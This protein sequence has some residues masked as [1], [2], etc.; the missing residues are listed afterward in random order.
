MK[1]IWILTAMSEEAQYIID[2]YGLQKTQS[3]ATISF[4]E[5]DKIVL[6]LAGVGKVQ[7][8]IATTLLLQ[9]FHPQY[10]INIGIAGSLVGREA[11]VGDV[12]LID[13]IIQHD[14]YLPFEGEHLDYAK[15]EIT[16]PFH[17]LCDSHNFDFTFY[18]SWKCL[19]WDQFLDDE[20]KVQSLRKQRNAQV[21]EMEAFAFASV[22]REFWKLDSSIVIKAVSDGGDSDAKSAHMDNLDFAMQN[23]LSVLHKVITSLS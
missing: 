22:A 16:L 4:Y 15:G 23:S 8:S 2:H 3:L 21:V 17:P 11:K 1:K 7:A 12:F 19:T 5:N 9:N 13:K 20:Q 14:M 18:L 10:L 6:A